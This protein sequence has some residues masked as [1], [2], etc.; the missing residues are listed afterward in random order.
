M[1]FSVVSRLTTAIS[2][3]VLTDAGEVLLRS[4]D[5]LHWEVQEQSNTGERRTGLNRS[6]AG[7]YLCQYFDPL[8]IPLTHLDKSHPSIV[9]SND[10][11]PV[12]S[13][14]RLQA[15]YTEDALSDVNYSFQKGYVRH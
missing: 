2:P 15:R 13:K 11:G 5:G 10:R 7:K 8:Q 9:I 4:K 14:E 3:P 12:I 1:R 6:T